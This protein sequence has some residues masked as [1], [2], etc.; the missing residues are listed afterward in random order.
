MLV[1]HAKR[2]LGTHESA[3]RA[4]LDHT[5]LVSDSSQ[6]RMTCAFAVQAMMQVCL[7]PVREVVLGPGGC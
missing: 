4:C 3:A 2:L 6:G 1:P 5:Q 7:C